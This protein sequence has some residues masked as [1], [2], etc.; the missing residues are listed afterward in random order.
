[1]VAL[2]EPISTGDVIDRSVRLY[3]KNFGAF[4]LLVALP[5]L[6]SYA[7]ALMAG[8][9]YFGAI[10]ETEPFAAIGHLVMAGAGYFIAYIISPLLYLFV[11][12]ALARSSADHIMLGTPI[13]FRGAIKLLR[14]RVGQIVLAWV[15]LMAIVIGVSAAAYF[16]LVALVLLTAAVF[17]LAQGASTWV[18]GATMTFVVA[19]GIGAI[20]VLLL[21]MASRICFLPQVMMIEGRG[22]AESL[23]RSFQLGGRNW[24]RLGGI[25]LFYYFVVASLVAALLVPVGVYFYLNRT[26]SSLNEWE[27]FSWFA[28]LYSTAS[29]FSTIVTL[30]ILVIGLTLLYFDNRVRKEAYDIELMLR[31]LEPEV[32]AVSPVEG[33]DKQPVNVTS[34]AAPYCRN[35]GR[36]AVSEE[37]NFCLHCGAALVAG[38]SSVA[39]SRA[40]VSVP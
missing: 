16:V 4:A 10:R 9:G 14:G 20:V 8:F 36:Q 18:V 23:R 31:Q 35:C 1:M 15:L 3:R 37:A 7:A 13:T 21:V 39:E 28:V 29:Q 2:L 24:Y 40:E 27:L 32:L 34:S 22:A 17:S 6:V 26:F 25:L 12:A 19:T 38:A 11:T 30:P 5:G 33:N